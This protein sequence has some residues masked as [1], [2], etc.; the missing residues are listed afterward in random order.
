[1][2]RIAITLILLMAAYGFGNAEEIKGYKGFNLG[3]DFEKVYNQ[4]R[5][6]YQGLEISTDPQPG[7]GA[8]L[9]TKTSTETVGFYFNREYVLSKIVVDTRIDDDHYAKLM[10]HIKQKYGAPKTESSMASKPNIWQ[11][12]NR[13]VTVYVP[14]RKEVTVVYADLSLIEVDQKPFPPL[15]VDVKSF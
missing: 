2:K 7:G 4:I 9:L 5:D 11:A 10:E 6:V 14:F 8:R 12:G 15:R 13:S 1:M 3:D